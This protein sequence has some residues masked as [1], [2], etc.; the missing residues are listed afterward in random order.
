MKTLVREQAWSAVIEYSRVVL[1]RKLA[2]SARDCGDEGLVDVG[3]PLGEPRTDVANSGRIER[4]LAAAFRRDK[5]NAG[6]VPFGE[7]GRY[8]IGGGCALA[9]A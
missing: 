2:S 9:H 1:K 8:A 5:G 4:E 7:G 6:C 3:K